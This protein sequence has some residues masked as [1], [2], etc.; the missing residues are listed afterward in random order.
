MELTKNVK[1]LG[2][3]DLYGNLLT[4]RQRQVF[5]LYALKDLSL[6]EV[7]DV[8]KITRQAVKFALDSIEKSLNHYEEILKIKEKFDI[9]KNELNEIKEISDEKLAQK[10]D[11]ILEEL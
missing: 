5:D 6:K 2:L 10:I 4:E 9:L 7:A 1:L 3:Y 11:K 8:L